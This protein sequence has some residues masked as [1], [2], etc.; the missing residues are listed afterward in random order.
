MSTSTVTARVDAPNRERSTTKR[1]SKRGLGFAVRALR[2]LLVMLWRPLHLRR[3]SAPDTW[4]SFRTES[5]VGYKVL[6]DEL[7]HIPAKGAL[8]TLSNQPFGKLESDVLRA[9][10]RAR[11]ND[12]KVLS[13]EQALKRASDSTSLSKP[14]LEVRDSARSWV[15]AGHAL[16]MLPAGGRSRFIPQLMRV[17]DRRW[18]PALAS[19]LRESNAQVLPI[20]FATPN[21]L[22][23]AL[24][25]IPKRIRSWLRADSQ[26][27]R[28]RIGQPIPSDKLQAEAPSEL[29]ANLRLRTYMLLGERE[30]RHASRSSAASLP[31]TSRQTQVIAARETVDAIASEIDSLRAEFKLMESAGVE[32]FCAPRDRLDLVMHEIGRLRELTFRSVGEGTGKSLDISDFDDRYEHLFLWNKEDRE[33]VG[34]YRLGCTDKILPELGIP[35]LY[36]NRLFAYRERFFERIGPAIEL[37]R[38]FVQPRYQRSYSPLLLLWKGIGAYVANYPHYRS[39]FGPVSISIEYLDTSKQLIIAYLEAHAHAP[40]LARYVRAKTP[41]RLRRIKGWELQAARKAVKNIEDLSHFISEAERDRKGV[42]VLLKQYIKFGARMLAMNVDS[43]FAD[44]LDGMMVV[45]L[46]DTDPRM[47]QRYMGNDA[48]EAYLERWTGV[49]GSAR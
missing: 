9:L 10:L 46:P 13:N 47:L 31:S 21:P 5:G 41:P 37:G 45:E 3:L 29:M 16:A 25:W 33:I 48:A 36:S 30:R 2:R 38:S 23:C 18:E 26:P 42:P 19:F 4:F 11:R 7:A 49:A 35:G 27:L 28:L 8:I 6:K 40:E 39:L 1:K 14:S 32:V 22:V 12:V 17:A 44:V 43:A 15:Q 20:A 34:G 24:R